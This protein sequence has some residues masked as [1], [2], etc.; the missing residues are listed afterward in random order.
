MSK[1]LII[2]D[3]EGRTIWKDIIKKE[4]PDTTVFLGDYVASRVVSPEQELETLKEVIAYKEANPDKVF[5]LRGNHDV[6]SLGYSWAGCWPVAPESSD[7]WMQNN[8]SRFLAATQWIYQIPDTNIICSHAG[9]GKYFLEKCEKWLV[10]NRGSQYTDGTIDTGIVLDLINT[11]PPCNLFGFTGPSWDH[12]GDS[13]TQPCTWIRP[14]ALTGCAI[15]NYVQIV[16]H[17]RTNKIINYRGCGIWMC[18]ALDYG[19]Y[20][21]IDNDEFIPKEL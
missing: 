12:S 9:I 21:V 17:T 2:S 4:N 10:E 13:Y 7:E 3:L 11:I 15:E 6:C 18:D 14:D 16:G 1:I 5:L 19:M 20:L 8:E